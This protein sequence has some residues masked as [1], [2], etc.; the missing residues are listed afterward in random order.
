MKWLTQTPTSV[1]LAILAGVVLAYNAPTIYK[2]LAEN[3]FDSNGNPIVPLCDDKE[4]EQFRI[5]QT[6]SNGSWISE[7]QFT[8]YRQKDYDV[9]NNIRTCIS[10]A[11]ILSKESVEAGDR[12]FFETRADF[13]IQP[14][15]EGKLII[16]EIQ[17]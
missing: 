2:T 11:K 3:A 9:E 16:E 5:Q 13:A 7:V 12:T 14:T 8:D 1:T 4:I 10:T 15:T 6:L 17:P